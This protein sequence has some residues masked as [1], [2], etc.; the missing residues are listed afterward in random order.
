VLRGAKKDPQLITSSW[1]TLQELIA[2]VALRQVANVPGNRGV[3]TEIFRP[4]WDPSGGP[5]GQI[6]QVRLFPAAISAWHC[7]LT[8]VDRLFIGVGHVRVVLYDARPESATHGRINEFHLGESRSGLLIVPPQVWHGV[9]NVGGVP[10]LL[11]NAPTRPYDYEDPDHY[12]L[13]ANTPEIPF[14]WDA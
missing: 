5:V 9:Q 3:L 7:H 10:A 8:A 1:C 2:G 13:P 4:E 14:T 6:F 12:R 11:L